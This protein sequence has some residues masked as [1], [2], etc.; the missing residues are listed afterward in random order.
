MIEGIG[1]VINMVEENAL[2]DPEGNCKKTFYCSFSSIHLDIFSS[3]AD[4]TSY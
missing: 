1:E 4:E 2:T 3:I